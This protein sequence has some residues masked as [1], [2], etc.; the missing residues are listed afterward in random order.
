MRIRFKGVKLTPARYMLLA[1]FIK[2][3]PGQPPFSKLYEMQGIED[4]IKELF[5]DETW[6]EISGEVSFQTRPTW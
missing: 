4:M 2:I 5:D 3:E 1:E 6:T